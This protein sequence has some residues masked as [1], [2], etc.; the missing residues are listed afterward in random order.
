MPVRP[1]G[2][3]KLLV[4][5]FELTGNTRWSTDELRREVLSAFEGRELT[6]EDLETARRELTQWYVRH[7]YVNSGAR[8]PDQPVSGGVV[9]IA[10]VEG[11]LTRVDVSGTHHLNERYLTERL[12]SAAGT[13]LHVGALADRLRQLQERPIID[14]L[15]A[16][17]APGNAP[18]ESVLAVDVQEAPL[19][20]GGLTI[21]NNRSPSIGPIRAQ[22]FAS[23]RSLTGRS[24]PLLLRLGLARR[25][26]DIGA[27][28]SLPLTVNDLTLNLRADSSDS[29]VVEAPFSELDIRSRTRIWSIGLSRPF[30][31][32]PDHGHSL[33]IAL[34]RK[35]NQTWL[36]GEPFSF[37]PGVENGRSAVSALRLFHEMFR[38]SAAQALA[39]RTGI[40]V[41]IDAFGAT[42][43]AGRPDGRFVS[44]Q[45]QLQWLRRFEDT[46]GQLYFR[47]DFQW[48]SDTLLPL[49]KIAV[50]G[51]NTVRGYR[52][53]ALVRDQALILSLEWRQSIDRWLR[54]SPDSS[55]IGEFQIAPFIDY[56]VTGNRGTPTPSPRSLGSAGV[57]ARWSLP[58]RAFAEIA[59]GHGF[60]RLSPRGDD[61]QDK[62]IHFR[63]TVQTR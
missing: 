49:E 9:T 22:L 35:R 57:V 5:R 26:D 21:A 6:A 30:A 10:I 58:S 2:V 34:E 42:T 54:R 43:G 13:P 15:R 46:A 47:S 36:L 44:M 33:G 40:N 18:G 20:Q 11:R 14:R 59:Y 45:G 25:L 3:A 39:V 4:R 55:A 63:V 19:W 29:L 60:R 38:R 23:A 12:L 37:S 32:T 50:G 53:S 1:G 8:I 61:L 41:G 7:G 27:D 28:Y 31:S 56:A 51:A 52:E 17:L 48:A 24:D 16:N 62:G